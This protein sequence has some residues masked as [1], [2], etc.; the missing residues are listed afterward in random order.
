MPEQRFQDIKKVTI[1][2]DMPGLAAKTFYR[3]KY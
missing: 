2:E 1:E 3:N